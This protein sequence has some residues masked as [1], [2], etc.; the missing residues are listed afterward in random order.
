MKTSFY[1]LILVILLIL[2]TRV[3]KTTCFGIIV[4]FDGGIQ[5]TDDFLQ[6]AA[7]SACII[8]E[9]FDTKIIGLD[10]INVGPGREII[11]LGG[12]SII[13]DATT[14][15]AK[16]EYEGLVFGFQGLL[17]F[18]KWW[19]TINSSIDISKSI[20]VVQGDCKNV[21]AQMNGV[22]RPRKLESYHQKCQAILRSELSKYDIIFQHYSASK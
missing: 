13:A 21:V 6:H 7:C 14:T 2:L 17:S 12:R 20:I 5:K 10:T 19:E 22:A 11:N 4:Q 18:L 15:S 8:L 16:V 1:N 3:V 9:S